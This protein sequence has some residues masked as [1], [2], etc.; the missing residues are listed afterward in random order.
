V[1]E[2]LSFTAPDKPGAE[3]TID[4]AYVESRVAALAQSADMSRY[5]L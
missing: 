4:R 5:V 1:F 3:V 2:D